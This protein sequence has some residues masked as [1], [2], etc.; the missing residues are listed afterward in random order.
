M[1]IQASPERVRVTR[2]GKWIW[3]LAIIALGVA[4]GLIG[5]DTFHLRCERATD[6]CTY[7]SLGV[8]QGGVHDG[9]FA[10]SEVEL[11]VDELEERRGANAS[12]VYYATRHTAWLRDGRQLNLEPRLR[13]RF[14]DD[15]LPTRFRAFQSRGDATLDIRELHFGFAGIFV[16]ACMLIGLMLLVLARSVTLTLDRRTRSYAFRRRGIVGGFASREGPFSDL[17]QI[18]INDKGSY[19][20]VY[21]AHR[22]GRRYKLLYGGVG[23]EGRSAAQTIAE[24]LGVPLVGTDD[25][26]VKAQARGTLPFGALGCMLLAVS[27]LAVPGIWCVLSWLF[28]ELA[29]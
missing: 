14:I 8:L 6:R 11:M 29:T 23:H 2:P 28:T 21:L 25:A 15:H 7:Q 19:L 5:V 17:V 3:P 16:I 22:E 20:G 13:T 24:T 27:P 10:L 9:R 18:E 26:T 4:V 12:T 1:K